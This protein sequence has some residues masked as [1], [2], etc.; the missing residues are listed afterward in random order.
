LK[1]YVQNELKELPWNEEKKKEGKGKGRK[2]K[3]KGNICEAL[4]SRLS[5][6]HFIYICF[7]LL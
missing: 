7:Q 1:K 4:L 3:G 2:Q 6:N 5:T